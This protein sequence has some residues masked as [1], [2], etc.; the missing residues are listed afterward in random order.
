M[1]KK[2]SCTP[3]QTVTK[4]TTTKTTTSLRHRAH[5]VLAEEERE[6]EG[7]TPAGDESLAL[8]LRLLGGKERRAVREVR[9]R[10]GEEQGGE[11]MMKERGYGKG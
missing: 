2:A 5:G 8:S 11:G 1:G 10:R 6:R 9:G 4:T 7:Q 3:G